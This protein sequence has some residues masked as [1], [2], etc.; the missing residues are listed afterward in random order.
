MF[1]GQDDKKIKQVYAY[2]KNGHFCCF[3]FLFDTNLWTIV[4][5]IC[6]YNGNQPES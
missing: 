3:F 5:S 2:A 4:Y 1:L 6:K